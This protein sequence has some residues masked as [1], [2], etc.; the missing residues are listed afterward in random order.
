MNKMK[1]INSYHRE[2]TEDD[3][4]KKA[5]RAFVGGMWE[6][7]GKLQFE[8]MRHVGLK[9]EHKLLDIGC[10]CLRGGLH[11]INYLENGNYFGLDINSSL[12]NAGKVEMLEAG[13]S[14]KNPNLLVDDSFSIEKFNQ[15]FDFMISVSLF[16]HLP[17][18]IIQICLSKV[19]ENLKPAGQH[20]STFFQAPNSA[21][22][23]NIRQEPGGIVTKCNSDP[24]HYSVDEIASAAESAGLNFTM[25]GDWQHPRNQKMASFSLKN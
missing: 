20:Y 14:F 12:I 19:R 15:K 1:G 10:G 5:H 22:T 11:F 13:L 9:P 3:V 25:Y 17:L 24:F 18:D 2:L 21:H 23:E 8:F 4:S 7:I 16:T 6:E